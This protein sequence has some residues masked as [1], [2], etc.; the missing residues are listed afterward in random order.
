M[1]WV[2][3]R[4][5]FF[6]FFFS[7]NVFFSRHAYSLNG[8]PRHPMRGLGGGGAGRPTCVQFCTSFLDHHF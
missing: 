4:V 2:L 8:N 6:F 5:F 3:F 7:L 1:Q